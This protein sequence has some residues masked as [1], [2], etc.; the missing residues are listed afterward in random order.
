V[1]PLKNFPA[2]YGTQRFITAFKT[3]PPLVPILSQTNP[4][5]TTPSYLSNINLDIDK[6]SAYQIP[7]VIVVLVALVLRH[8]NHVT[9]LATINLRANTTHVF[10]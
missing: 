2:F 8:D 5:H 9:L 7:S 10:I 6:R 1:Q 4:V 3:S